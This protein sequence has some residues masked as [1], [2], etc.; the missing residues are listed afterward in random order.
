MNRLVFST[1]QS[2]DEKKNKGK[3]K[4]T[5]RYLQGEGPIKIQVEKKGR[6]GKVVTVLFD[7]PL[8]FEHAKELMKKLQENLACGGT[9]KDSK[10]EFLEFSSQ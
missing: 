3:K 8:D 7:L 6:G 1:S 9:L 2:K 4:K 5:N 10:I